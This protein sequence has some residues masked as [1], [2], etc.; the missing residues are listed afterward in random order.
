VAARIEATSKG[1]DIRYVVTN[2]E[3]GSAE[4]LYDGLYCGRGQAEILPS[5]RVSNLIGVHGMASA[6]TS[7][8]A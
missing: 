4:W 8:L 7:A 5:W 2:L 1:L 3:F 6:A